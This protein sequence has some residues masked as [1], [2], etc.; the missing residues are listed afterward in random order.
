[1]R[2]LGLTFFS[3]SHDLINELFHIHA[4]QGSNKLCKYWIFEDG[5]I[6]IAKSTGFSRTDL[7]KIEKSLDEN[8][9]HI[10]TQYE[11]YCYENRLGIN[12]KTKHS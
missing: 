7:K 12:F 3:L 4:A 6:E 9:N 5:S 10:I 2:V 1:M 11:T 8:I